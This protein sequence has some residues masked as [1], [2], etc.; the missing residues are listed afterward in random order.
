MANR[1]PSAMGKF[2]IEVPRTYDAAPERV[3][4]AWTDPASVKVWLAGAKTRRSILA[5][6]GCST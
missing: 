4:R 6:A 5:R 1:N 3:F 2:K